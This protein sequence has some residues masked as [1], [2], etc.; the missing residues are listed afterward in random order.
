MADRPSS[1]PSSPTREAVHRGPEEPL[2]EHHHRKVQGGAARAAVFGISDG[3]VSNVSLILG[4][5]G[6]NP[7]PGVV[8]LAG[9]AG[10]VGGAFSMAAGEYV[11]MRAQTELLERELEMERVELR[12]SPENERRELAAIYQSR[13]VAPDIADELAAQMMR[14]PELA[15]ETH[16][17]EELGIDPEELGSPVQASVSSFLAFAF[18]AV[19]PLIP[20]FVT[21]GT[22]G[23]I[24]SVVV[25]A[26]AAVAIGVALAAFTG[27]S[28]VRSALRQLAIA[29]A[30]AGVTFA[31]GNAVGVG[32]A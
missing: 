21:R 6:A 3:L 23:T 5:A 31:V 1:S 17:R 22:A 10:L 7:A 8:R 24:G 19:L 26:L 2:H 12:R 30:A 16:A 28:A 13:G 14:D 9:L 25:G 32:V 27:R 11:S 4:V 29:A 18:G 20:W 15:L